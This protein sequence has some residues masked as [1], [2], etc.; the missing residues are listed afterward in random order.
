MGLPYH[1]Q[2]SYWNI[3]FELVLRKACYLPVELEHR[4]LWPL[5]KLNFQS[6]EALE[7]GLTQLHLLDDFRLIAYENSVHYKEKMKRWHD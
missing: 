1:L 3:P 6:D 5:K 2:G 4:T 7:A